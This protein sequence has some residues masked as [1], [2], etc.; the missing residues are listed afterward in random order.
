MGLVVRCYH[1]RVTV[2]V[3]YHHIGKLPGAYSPLGVDL[4]QDGAMDVLAVSSFNDWWQ[5]KPTSMVW[6][7]NDGSQQFETHIL[8]HAPTHLLGLDIGHFDDSGKPSF[9]TGAFHAYP[10]YDKLSRL[11]LWQMQPAQ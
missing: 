6:F 5:E 2:L 4:D 1:N 10:P 3:E 9:V 11:T 8:A 7:K